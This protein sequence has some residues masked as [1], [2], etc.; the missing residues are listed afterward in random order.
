MVAIMMVMRYRWKSMEKTLCGMTVPH[1]ERMER[2]KGERELSNYAT[3]F[4]HIWMPQAPTYIN[5]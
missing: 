3:R 1:E 5:F 4:Y 2:R